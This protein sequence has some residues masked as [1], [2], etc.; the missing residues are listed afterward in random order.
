MVGVLL[1][2]LPA[3]F[4]QAPDAFTGT[5]KLNADKSTGGYRA[6]TRTYKPVAS[7][8]RVIF[9][10]TRNDGMDTNGE[11]TTLCQK[12]KCT[13]LLVNWIEKGLRRVEGQTFD[14]GKAAERYRREVSTDGKTM[15]ITFFPPTGKKKVTSVQIWDKQ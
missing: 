11:Y 4:A 7:G 8:T 12:G 5:W 3:A 2:T 13:S 14:N 9:A 1:L 10:M 15:K 6:G